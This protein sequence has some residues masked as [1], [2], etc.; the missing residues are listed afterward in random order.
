MKLFPALL[1]VS[2]L[3]IACATPAQE[4]SEVSTIEPSVVP[5]S[6]STSSKTPTAEATKEVSNLVEFIKQE[7]SG[8]KIEGATFDQINLVAFPA[9]DEPGN[10]TNKDKKV[11][12]GLD[13]PG[14][15]NLNC[16]GEVTLPSGEKVLT[17]FLWWKQGDKLASGSAGGHQYLLGMG[18]LSGAEPFT[19]FCKNAVDLWLK[20]GKFNTTLSLMFNPTNNNGLDPDF[21]TSALTRLEPPAEFWITGDINLL[22]K[23]DGKPFFLS[24]D[25]AFP[26][27]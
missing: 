13:G 22:P 1:I 8:W 12:F 4:T 9:D 19:M 15:L 11:K 21:F 2:F 6:T 10:H 25:F 17:G 26:S 27:Q 20:E 18:S 23:V 14:Q 24:T 7:G 3:L 5:T 16:Y